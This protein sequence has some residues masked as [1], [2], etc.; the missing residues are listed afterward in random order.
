MG[1]GG[2]KR[3]RGLSGQISPA[4]VHRGERNHDRDTRSAL[5]EDRLDCVQGGARVQRVENRL[6]QQDMRAA[7]EQSAHRI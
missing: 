3:L 7:V 1:D 6:D 2:V 5:F 4:E